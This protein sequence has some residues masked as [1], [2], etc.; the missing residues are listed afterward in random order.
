M[1]ELPKRGCVLSLLALPGRLAER[2]EGVLT[3]NEVVATIANTLIVAYSIEH[4]TKTSKELKKE[5]WLRAV[6][7]LDGE[8]SRVTNKGVVV[9]RVIQELG[10]AA[11]NGE[12][13]VWCLKEKQISLG[14]VVFRKAL[15]EEIGD[16][17]PFEESVELQITGMQENSQ[18]IDQAAHVAR[19][20]RHPGIFPTSPEV[21]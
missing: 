21:G 4:N 14:Y 7:L 17:R 2:I 8:M 6:N 1:V 10:K 13:N 18:D 9:R 3:E 11:G 15:E 20:L 12:L 5:V 16:K 19:Y